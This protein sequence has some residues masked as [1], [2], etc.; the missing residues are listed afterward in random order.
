MGLTDVESNTG[1]VYE[2]K[3]MQT[4]TFNNVQ[5]WLK[6][7]TIKERGT[8]G[9]ALQSLS[10]S[11]VRVFFT[12]GHE[13]GRALAFSRDFCMFFPRMICGRVTYFC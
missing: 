9:V 8:Q 13:E 4:S 7:S 12:K 3:Y 10:Y 2:F 5:V 11:G 6:L 1:A